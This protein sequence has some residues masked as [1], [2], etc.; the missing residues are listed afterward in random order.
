MVKGML[1]I[2]FMAVGICIAVIIHAIY[3][4]AKKKNTAK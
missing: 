1:I 4:D 2:A 3:I